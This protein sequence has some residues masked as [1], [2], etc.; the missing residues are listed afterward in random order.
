MQPFTSAL[1][2][3]RCETRTLG[4]LLLLFTWGSAPAFGQIAGSLNV[5]MIDSVLNNNPAESQVEPLPDNGAG[6]PAE[7]PAGNV[8]SQQGSG[9]SEELSKPKASAPDQPSPQPRPSQATPLEVKRQDSNGAGAPLSETPLPPES[10]K[11]VAPDGGAQPAQ[12][13]DGR[14]GDPKG[15]A[16]RGNGTV[17]PVESADPAPSS[18]MLPGGMN[19]DAAPVSDKPSAEPRPLEREAF[20]DK[21]ESPVDVPSSNL[22]LMP[23]DQASPVGESLPSASPIPSNLMVDPRVPIDSAP[24][25]D[26]IIEGPAPPIPMLLPE[27]QAPIKSDLF[28]L[29]GGGTDR[30]QDEA[31][32]LLGGR[33]LRRLIKNS[34]RWEPMASCLR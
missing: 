30:R 2:L 26:P 12:A 3:P 27:S 21:R 28:P 10:S 24:Q 20:P 14:M 25:A 7:V 6:G 1:I 11:T 15:V 9:I 31:W 23:S 34:Q 18:I 33:L 4:S 22:N 32:K 17:M 5:P 16:P 29:S 19:L 8:S 13:D